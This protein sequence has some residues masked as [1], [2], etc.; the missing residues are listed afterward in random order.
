M[1]VTVMV[2]ILS[3]LIVL[4]IIVIVHEFGHFS[5]ARMLGIKVDEFSFGFGKELYAYQKQGGTRFKFC[6]IP[7]GGYVKMAGDDDASSLKKSERLAAMSEEE[8]KVCFHFQPVWKKFLVI[9]CGPLMN[10]VFAI[11]LLTGMF[12]F[13]G[14][15]KIDPVVGD[16]LKDSPAMVAGIQKGDLII[17]VNDEPISEFIEIKRAIGKYGIEPVNVYVRRDGKELKFVMKPDRKGDDFLIGIASGTGHVKY[18]K[19]GFGRAFCESVKLAWN[20]SADTVVYL[21]QMIRGKR[22]ADGMR[23]PLGIA[24]AS[25]DAFNMGFANFMLFLAHISVALGLFN[26]FPVPLLDGGHLVIYIVQCIRGGK[27]LSEKAEMILAY[28][29]FAV[30]IVL[31]SFAMWNDIY[32]LFNRVAD[33]LKK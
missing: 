12:T 3:F 1:I 7:L 19:I 15:T 25:G 28:T 2:Y 9:L 5:V 23:G 21:G 22:S 32:R 20:I 14:L 33:F 6:L 31:L 16:V 29:G 10:Y 24:E 13:Y 11:V 18:E 4:S 27:E 17:R 26:L 30:L 8:K